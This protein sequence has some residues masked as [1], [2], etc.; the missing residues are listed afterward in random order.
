MVNNVDPG[1]PGKP[2]VYP[3]YDPNNSTQFTVDPNAPG[4]LNQIPTST[5]YVWGYMTGTVDTS[6]IPSGAALSPGSQQA[7]LE[8][9]RFKNGST[10]S[11]AASVAAPINKH[12]LEAPSVGGYYD[13]AD[14][15]NTS[16]QPW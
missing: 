1:F 13:S 8:A 10:P 4:P 16:P 3:Y 7:S 2:T 5:T 9:L 14:T 11:G 15:A 6:A 12:Q